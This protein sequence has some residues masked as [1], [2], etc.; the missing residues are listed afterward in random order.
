MTL[1]VRRLHWLLGRCEVLAAAARLTAH[2]VRLREGV[3]RGRPASIDAAKVRA[4]KA[5]GMV[6]AEIDMTLRIGRA[7][8]YRALDQ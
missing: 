5:Q 1:R 4:M 7:A 3:Y 2:G 6:A 8:V